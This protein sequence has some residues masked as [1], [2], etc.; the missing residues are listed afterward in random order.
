M[1]LVRTASELSEAILMRKGPVFFVPTMGYLHEGHLSLLRMAAR[2][3]EEYEPRGTV[4]MSLFVNPTQFNDPKDLATYPRDEERDV[5]LAESAGCDV[6]F[7]P[8]VEEIYPEGLHGTTV[9]VPEVT[10]RWEGEFRPGHFVGVATVVAKLFNLVIP[11][12]AYFGEK[13]WQQCRVIAKM[14]HDLR[15]PVN[16]K[17]GK[18]V[19]E[20]DGLAMSSR[21]ALLPPEARSRAPVLYTTLCA[22]AEDYSRGMPPREAEQRARERLLQSKFS[23]VDYI[24]IV[25]E[26][27]LEPVESSNHPKARVLGAAHIGGVRLIDNVSVDEK[28]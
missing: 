13:D 7:A 17:F 18:T 25:D 2:D 12:F 14:V 27:S 28:D 15:M 19:R 16:L 3:C 6:V 24:A 5:R 9:H 22:C 11:D 8:S 26:E 20:S 1:Q 23:K 21:N 10:E 4:V